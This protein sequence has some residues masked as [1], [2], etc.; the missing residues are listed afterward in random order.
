[1]NTWTDADPR[2]QHPSSCTDSCQTHVHM[3]ILTPGALW[4]CEV[5]LLLSI[6]LSL[7]Y[8]P[9]LDIEFTL[10]AGDG[11]SDF[12]PLVLELITLVGGIVAALSTRGLLCFSII[13]G[14]STSSFLKLD[15]SNRVLSATDGGFSGKGGAGPLPLP[16]V[17][18]AL[19]DIV[20][21]IQH[22][23]LF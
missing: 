5:S 19:D 7:L 2:Q 21:F 11:V 17:L 22:T 3:C 4:L 15:F 23:D 1:M 16:W 14:F 8:L 13:L 9:T 18:L 12:S 10:L 6:I 20:V